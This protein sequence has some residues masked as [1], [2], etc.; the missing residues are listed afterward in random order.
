ME[1]SYICKS[2][3]FAQ[4]RIIAAARWIYHVGGV[5]IGSD[6]P[7]G[8]PVDSG[9][10]RND[11]GRPRRERGRLDD[12]VGRRGGFLTRTAM[13]RPVPN[14]GEGYGEGGD[15]PYVIR[16]L[17]DVVCLDSCFRKND[18]EGGARPTKKPPRD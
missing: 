1:D 3:N 13:H 17:G 9:F 18:E 10:R 15:S 2:G 14:T 5:R 11:G 16:Q 7:N 6:A 8:G 4:Q 12:A